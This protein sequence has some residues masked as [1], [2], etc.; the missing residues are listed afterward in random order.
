MLQ[1]YAERIGAGDG[2]LNLLAIGIA[3]SVV[4]VLFGLIAI[5]K[6][7]AARSTQDPQGTMGL[8]GRV[9]KL[10]GTLNEFRTN[11]TRSLEQ[12][13]AD[14]Q[15]IITELEYIRS[16]LERGGGGGVGNGG[17]S[18]STPPSSGSSGR[19]GGGSGGR[20]ASS[21]SHEAFPAPIASEEYFEPEALK[22]VEDRIIGEK[23][24]IPEVRESLS[25]RLAK[26]RRGFFDKIKSVFR[27]SPK[28]DEALVEELEL[29][30][31]SSD[32]GVKT[33]SSLLHEV[34]QE[35]VRGDEITE[36]ALTQRLKSKLIST[37]EI[38]TKPFAAFA[39][40]S[41]GNP[42]V[43]MMVGVNGVGKTT[44]SAKLA[45]QLKDAGHSVMLVAAD[46]FRAAAVEQLVEWGRRIDVPVISGAFEAKPQ[47]VVFD[48]MVEAKDK[49]V[50]FVIVDTAGRLHTKSSLMQELEG[51]RNT[52]QKHVAAAPQ[53]VFL[54]VDGTTGQNAIAQAREFHEVT[55]LTGLIVTKLDGTPKGGVV[56][57]IKEELGIPVRFIGV[58]EGKGDLRP[59][60]ATE[61]VE[62]IFGAAETSEAPERISA[63]GE[64]RRRRR[65]DGGAS[66]VV[67]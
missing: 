31:I 55:K 43:I 24:P 38:D 45:S 60:I 41:S 20:S 4:A 59:F 67:M 52:I 9:E 42:V 37:L 22:A 19:S 29:L 23:R 58:G 62:A 18:G 2:V 66:D 44:T 65:R 61:F 51:V 54:V 33:V 14:L 47:A 35:V 6:S 53:E 17:T 26:T 30:L 25:Q 32:L 7:E 48:A 40:D 36:D 5:R 21:E 1:S 13:R 28:L 34:K 15:F 64:T 8:G 56:V 50:Q 39:P 16:S 27:T 57:A 10:E 46:T 3:F 12:F 63:H 49:N 11:T